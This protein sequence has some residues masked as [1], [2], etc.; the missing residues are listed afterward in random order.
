ML[1]LVLAFA[2]PL[3]GGPP[4][5]SWTDS[6]VAP[7]VDDEYGSALIAIGG[8]YDLG[9]YVRERDESFF[10]DGVRLDR[11]FM[12]ERVVLVCVT[13]FELFA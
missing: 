1:R 12:E 7:R 10:G 13:D 4:G 5:A 2:S 6:L 8:I 9:G 3:I 11:I